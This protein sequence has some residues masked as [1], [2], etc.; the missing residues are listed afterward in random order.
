MRCDDKEDGENLLGQCLGLEQLAAYID[1]KLTPA[2]QSIIEHHLAEC[3]HC[4]GVVEIVIKSQS[5]VPSP[6]LPDSDN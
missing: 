5:E 1:G 4:R 2:E 3:S 6:L